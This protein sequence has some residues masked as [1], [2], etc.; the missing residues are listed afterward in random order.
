MTTTTMTQQRI[1]QQGRGGGMAQRRGGTKV[2]GRVRSAVLIALVLAGTA[3]VAGCN[4]SRE[5][6]LQPVAPVPE[7]TQD[8]G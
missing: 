6:M 2:R 3:G 4:T 8:Q 5:P 7:L 1:R